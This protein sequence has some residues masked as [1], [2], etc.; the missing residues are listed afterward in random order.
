M[1]FLSDFFS[2]Y[3]ILG[4][5]FV[6]YLITRLANITSLPLFTDEAIYIR[7]SQIARFDPNWRFISLTDGKQPLFVWIDMMIMRVVN[8]PLLAGRL[9]SVIAGA[10]SIIGIYF[11]ASQIFGKRVN[12][13]FISNRS[14]GLFASLIY[15]VFPFALV[16]DRMALYDS[17]VMAFAIWA[18]YFEIL[19]VRLKRLDIALILGM[20]IGGGILTKTSAFFFIYLLPFSIILLEFKKFSLKNL[21]SLKPLFKWAGLA[22]ISTLFALIYYSVLRLSP[23]Y[24]TINEKNGIFVYPFHDWITH[25]FTFFQ[26]N[27]MGMF[28]WIYVYMS[29]PVLVLVMAAFFIKRKEFFWEKMLLAIWFLAPFLALAMFGRIL[30]PRF[31]LF[32]TVPLLVLAAYSLN[33]IVS[34]FKKTLVK[35]AVVVVFLIFMLRADFYI[36]ND[37]SRAPIPFSDLEQYINGWPAGGGSQEVISILLEESK[38]EKIFVAS[39]GTFGSLPTYSVE[40]YLGDNKN[41]EKEGIYPVPNTIPE[42]LLQRA[43]KM[44]TFVFFS[45]QDEFL[46]QIKNWPLK[47]VFEQKKGTG[48]S[49]TRLYR[50]VPN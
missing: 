2:K 22:L 28:N 46:N 44:P 3:Y 8:D 32:M 18:L 49:Y 15:L 14:V 40:I 10:F 6:G 9:V 50:V 35:A 31:I 34:R 4:V 48:N 45:N 30:Y 23:F 20:V 43:E 11:L 5:L 38:K 7:W 13:R 36:I 17:L 19:L 41:I 33:Y 37:L 16:Y 12:G 47:L 42:G 24:H 29:I 25:P 27:L 39:L 1:K 26:G 21:A